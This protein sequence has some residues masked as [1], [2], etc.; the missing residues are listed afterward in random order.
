VTIDYDMQ[1]ANM[2]GISG[3]DTF[4]GESVAL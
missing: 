2:K 1:G 4:L 3:Q